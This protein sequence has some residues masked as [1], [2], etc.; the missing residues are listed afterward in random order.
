[1]RNKLI[2]KNVETSL[3]VEDQGRKIKCIHFLKSK[4]LSLVQVKE[5]H[6]TNKIF[7]ILHLKILTN[8]ERQGKD[9]YT[10]NKK[11]NVRLFADTWITYDNQ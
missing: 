5:R 3:L 11:M 7:T 10:R 9:F 4:R 1:M 6:S 2:F 8:T